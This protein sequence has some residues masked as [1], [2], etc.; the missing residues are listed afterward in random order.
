MAPVRLTRRRAL[1]AG[2]ATLATSA[3]APSTAL[4]RR[5]ALF[6]L[7]LAGDGA[8]AASS[9]GWRTTRV[10]RA[11]RRFDLLGLRWTA[12]AHPEAQVR[13]RRTRGE[14][15]AWLALHATG[16]HAPDASRA[17]VLG[18]EPTW[19]N[20]ADEFQL[21]LRGRA[22]GLRV[23]FVRAKPAAA[24]AR[25]ITGR[26]ARRGTVRA[27]Q[28]PGALTPPRLTTR[29]EWG[30][31]AVPPR[32]APSFGAVQLAF[33]HHTVTTNDYGPEDSAAIVLGIARYHRD[34]N[35]W[36]DIGYN[37]LVDRYGQVFEGRAGGLELAVIGA[38]AQGFNS[39]STG[40]A[41][42]G[43]FRGIAQSGQG[44]A[45]LSHLLAWK[46]ALHAVPP[47]G[48]V[49]VTSAGGATNR[50]PAGRAVSF[51]RISGHRDGNQTTCPGDALYAQLPALR[52]EVRRRT[53]A[54]I[55][56]PSPA[57]LT[58]ALTAARVRYPTPARVTGQLRFE[59]GVPPAGT[60]VA[61]EFQPAGGAWQP[62]GR[63]SADAAG[64]Y[65]AALEVPASGL[66]RAVYPGDGGRAPVQAAPVAIAVLPRLT[67]ALSARRLRGTP[68]GRAR[69]R[70][71]RAPR[72]SA[73]RRRRSRPQPAARR[74]PRA[75][76][77][78][79]P[80]CRRRARRPRSAAGRSPSPGSDS[81][82]ARR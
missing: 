13:V 29:A 46:L 60:P 75:G 58:L 16:D 48:Q 31:A 19:T 26:L 20:T 35:G 76:T 59:D 18:T 3:L 69:R 44:T 82:R 51:E 2:A 25:S 79:R 8:A 22:P 36:N 39:L 32:E 78:A 37:F 49:T 63:A 40:V 34:S 41:C 33:V 14:W 72:R 55:A 15:S 23:R 21:R 64:R 27:A 6:E 10:H 28:V 54:A 80:A 42:L 45:A 57:R 66:V 71:P 38:Q 53:G 77:R 12:G 74:R 5:P 81:A 4:A 52:A 62:V 11:P 43:D 30:A 56:A 68:H 24:V 1:G 50:Y 70:G 7:D 73:R 47:E 65:G 61:L 9:A 67:F 17:R